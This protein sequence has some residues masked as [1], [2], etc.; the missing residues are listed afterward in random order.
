MPTVTSYGATQE[1]TGSCHILEVDGISIMID[2][3]MFQGEEEDQNQRPFA[4]DPSKID[5][6]LVT[7]AHLDHIGRIPKLVKEGFKGKI[8]ATPATKD[9]AYIILMDSAKIMNEDFETKYKKAARKATE[10]K[11]Q[12]PL[13]G[14][15]DVQSTF[16]KEWVETEY[17]EYYEI[18]EG[19]SV[20]YRNAGH[21]LG[22]AFL[23]ISYM[24]DGVSH[25]VV[26]SGDIGND[27][28]IVLP[29]LQ[30]C[31]KAD[32]LYVESTYGDR[33]HQPIESTIAEFKEVIIKTI[34]A[35]GNVLIP[36]FAVERTQELLYI[37]RDMHQ[38]KELPKCQ[39]FLD[40][41]MA[42]KATDVYHKYSEEL[43]ENC[44]ENIKENG[45]VF[46]FEWLTYTEEPEESK[47]I[48]DIDSRAIIIA[49]SGMC[50]GGRI[51]RHFKHKIWESKNA[52][53]FVGYQA[54]GTL[55][56]E[57]IEGA[58]WINIYNE[59]IIVKA[60]IHTINGF[61]A[62]ADQEGMIHWISK[63]KNLKKVFIIHGEKIAQQTF[64]EMITEKLHID[65]HIVSYG[66]KNEL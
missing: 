2:C 41:P 50:N 31:K 57:I 16:N 19:V 15:L 34:N 10:K 24:Q 35:G 40:S 60:S 7:H 56:R 52:I 32:F 14:P 38:K 9:L 64:K 37:L 6:L 30:K 55:G 58:E 27:N 26:F 3:G 53:V 33:N 18:C 17:D 46:D 4:F 66:E 43:N 42:T 8:Y 5:Y 62:H 49:G 61:S 25:T 51:T 36:S 22:A 65:T 54:M 63:I 1:V 29:N 13:Y 28:N 59:D 44:Q 21:I 45:S 23:E 39:V 48:N 47:A 12:K 20:A 11:L